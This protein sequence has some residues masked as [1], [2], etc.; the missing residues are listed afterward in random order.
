MEQNLSATVRNFSTLARDG[1]T[2]PAPVIDGHTE[3]LRRLRGHETRLLLVYHNPEGVTKREELPDRLLGLILR[4]GE[5]QPIVQVTEQSDTASVS[6]SRHRR[7]D[8]GKDLG[9]SRQTEEQGFELVKLSPP[10]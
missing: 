7:E 9:S 6:P 8:S 2:L 3:I 1:K 4:G 5:D 10:T